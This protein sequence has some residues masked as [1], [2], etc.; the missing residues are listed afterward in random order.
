MHSL[1]N[2]FFGI[3]FT[4]DGVSV[5]DL[6][7]RIPI[8]YSVLYLEYY[9]SMYPN[10]SQILPTNKVLYLLHGVFKFYNV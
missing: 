3:I 1:K 10:N 6:I 4:C 2:Q 7:L 9:T 8:I 5:L